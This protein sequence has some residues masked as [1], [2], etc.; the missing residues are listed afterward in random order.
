MR[1]GL[2]VTKQ[3]CRRMGKLCSLTPS[4]RHRVANGKGYETYTR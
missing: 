3:T 2:P 4:G 1:H